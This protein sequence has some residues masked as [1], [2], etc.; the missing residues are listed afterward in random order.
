MADSDFTNKP[1][2][3]PVCYAHELDPLYR[4]LDS[5]D[6]GSWQDVQRWRINERERLRT[7]RKELSVEQR[8]RASK[9]IE[10]A[11]NELLE[12]SAD[13]IIGAYWPIQQEVDLRD[14]M[15]Q[16][17]V[18]GRVIALPV[19]NN[20]QQPLQYV[21]WHPGCAMRWG[22]WGRCRTRRAGA[23]STGYCYRTATRRR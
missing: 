14:W 1:Y 18:N 17:S 22:I 3:S 2:T 8:H 20:K 21:R 5:T 23:G 11:L 7:A 10:S 4:D 16:Q 13:Q 15:T 9:E 6:N 19:I 12:H